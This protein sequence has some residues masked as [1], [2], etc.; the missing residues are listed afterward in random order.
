VKPVLPT[1]KKPAAAPTEKPKAE[2]PPPAAAPA[3]KKAEGPAPA[4]AKAPPARAPTQPPAAAPPAQ[5]TEQNATEVC[6]RFALSDAAKQLLQ[7]HLTLLPFLQVLVSRELFL[8][9]LRLLAHALPKREAVWW[10]CRC[11]RLERAELPPAEAA[12]LEAAEA[13]VKDPS[14]AN[15]RAAQAAAEA[16]EFTTPAGCAAIA[17]FWSGGSLSPPEAPVVPPGE[18]L[19]AQGVANA[20]LMAAEARQPEKAREHYS[21]FFTEGIGVATGAKK[22]PAG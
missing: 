4:A 12:A 3:E 15:R 6:K 2:A 5:A 13:W 14:E 16:A 9:A 17:A 1:G 20:V 10:A 19:T 21:Q 18:T 11:A 8:D 7:D 22:W